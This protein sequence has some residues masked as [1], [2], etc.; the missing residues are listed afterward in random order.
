MVRV[1]GFVE[2][3]ISARPQNILIGKLSASQPERVGRVVVVSNRNK[4]FEI[5]RMTYDQNLM[6]VSVSEETLE[7]PRGFILDVQPKLE[8]V[9]VGSRKQ[10]SLSIET[11]LS[12]NDKVEVMVNILNH[13]DQQEAQHK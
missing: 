2:G 9:P 1:S 5:T 8:G 11:D 4:P 12:P 10:G 6:S 13:S 7:N 3:E